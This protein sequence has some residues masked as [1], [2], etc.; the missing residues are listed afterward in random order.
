MT[1]SMEDLV[2]LSQT[3]DEA[4]QD[5]LIRRMVPMAKKLA[6]VNNGA[7]FSRTPASDYDDKVQEALVAIWRQALPK[8]NSNHASKASFGTLAW[9]WAKSGVKSWAKQQFNQTKKA[10]YGES[11]NGQDPLPFMTKMLRRQF[12]D[13][14]EET[15]TKIDVLSHLAQLPMDEQRVLFFRFWMGMDLR[16]VATVSGTPESGIKR[17]SRQT[18]LNIEKRALANLRELMEVA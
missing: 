5:E 13:E 17:M 7:P 8:Y 3:G 14:T 12:N 10:Q 6:S 11:Y 4:A 2:A 15:D 18:V 16:A 1:Q 9:W